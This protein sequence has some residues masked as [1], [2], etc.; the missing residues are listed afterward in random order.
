M[1][2]TSVSKKLALKSDQLMQN[3]SNL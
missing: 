2:T 3:S 1:K